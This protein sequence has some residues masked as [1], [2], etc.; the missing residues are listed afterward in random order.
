MPE[1][2][3]SK[4]TAVCYPPES[5]YNNWCA[6]ADRLEMTTSRFIIQMVEAGRKNIDIDDVPRDSIHDL[7]QARI[8]LEREVER[9]QEQ[10]RD[11]ERQL[12]RTSRTDIVE[13]VE[14][15][16]GVTTP[17]IIQQ[18]AN[19]V[20]GRVASHL[21]VLEGEVLTLQGGSYY[22]LKEDTSVNSQDED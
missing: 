8:E 1:L 10:I 7:R 3:P 14:E 17:E 15:N 19:T 22:P 6:H 18:V 13:F 11:L 16:P 4:V 20:P 5:L 2:G 9:Q 12:E 21:D